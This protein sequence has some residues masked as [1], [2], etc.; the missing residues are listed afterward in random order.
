MVLIPV[1][2]IVDIRIVSGF[3]VGE[4]VETIA[5]L[6]IGQAAIAAVRDGDP[7]NAIVGEVHGC[8]VAEVIRIGNIGSGWIRHRERFQPPI[9]AAA[10]IGDR[11]PDQEP[12]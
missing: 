2:H 6:R 3:R 1:E 12:R 5:E 7:T 8:G 9:K 10:E 11:V 4:I